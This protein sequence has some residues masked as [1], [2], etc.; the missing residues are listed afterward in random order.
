MTNTNTLIAVVLAMTATSVPRTAE[1]GNEPSAVPSLADILDNSEVVGRSD[2]GDELDQA[3]RAITT[4][5]AK[6]TPVIGTRGHG[7]VKGIRS[8]RATLKLEGIDP[9]DLDLVRDSKTGTKPAPN[10]IRRAVRRATKK[11]RRC[12][13]RA[14]G[15]Q[16]RRTGWMVSQLTIAPNGTVTTA[17]IV[18]STMTYR[19]GQCVK[20]VLG[21]LKFAPL[22]SNE[23]LEVI[24]PW[25]FAAASRRRTPAS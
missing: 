22:R 19:M 1:A 24:T 6:S 20:H 13:R 23:P 3:A 14:R 18:D 21:N 25:T 10:H 5:E 2:L 8:V 17:L 15:G 9:P 7:P 11:V 4:P 12:Y 16:A